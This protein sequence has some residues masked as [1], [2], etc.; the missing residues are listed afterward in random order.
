[1]IHPPSRDSLIVRTR[2][3]LRQAILGGEWTGRLPSERD[4]AARLRVCRATLRA[5]LAGLQRDGLLRALPRRGSWVQRGGV[6]RRPRTA[7]GVIGWL[8]GE[9]H[10][11]LSPHSQVFF[12]DIERRL[13]GAGFALEPHV[14]SRPRGARLD[15][16]LADL[17]SRHRCA[18]WLLT[19]SSAEMQAWFMHRGLATLVSGHCHPNVRLPAV[20]LHYEAVC[21]HAVATLCRAGCRRLALLAPGAAFGG[22][23][24]TLDSYAAALR[25]AAPGGV[26][27]IILRYED[28]PAKVER[29][30]EHA[31]RGPRRPDGLIVARAAY[32]ITAASVLARLGLRPG[33]DMALI[34]RDND[35]ALDWVLPP[36]ARYAINPE[37]HAR[38]VAAVLLDLASGG[39]AAPRM[40]R[41]VPRFM[42]AGTAGLGAVV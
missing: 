3:A 38:R 40:L 17:T 2:T 24:L 18:A 11:R 9:P 23:L 25:A 26:S 14:L 21:R 32:A 10:A 1:M 36:I 22:D 27:G 20:D 42:P 5:A 30:L 4:L 37:R 16:R 12:R 8:D 39:A 19:L 41:L 31:C 34:S 15:A 28:S 6:V 13:A 35:P 7:T 29:L 33:R